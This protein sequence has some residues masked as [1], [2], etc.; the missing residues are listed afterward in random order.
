VELAGIITKEPELF[1]RAL[2]SKLLTYA[3]GRGLEPADRATVRRISRQVAADGYKFSAL[4]TDIVQ[5]PQ[6][7]MRAGTATP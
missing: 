1:T 7:Q 2:T 4:I 3:L 5:S 6:F